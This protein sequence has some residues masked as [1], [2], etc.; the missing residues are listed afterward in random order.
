MAFVLSDISYIVVWCN[1]GSNW[2]S[3]ALIKKK[4]ACRIYHPGCRFTNDI[5]FYT[6][7]SFPGDSH[8]HHGMTWNRWI[9]L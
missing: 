8:A 3:I 7:V 5:G 9:Q 4:Q 6:G 2:W 1:P